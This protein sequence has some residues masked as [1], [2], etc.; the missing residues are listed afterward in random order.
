MTDDR[1]VL[2]RLRRDA[3]RQLDARPRAVE[4]ASVGVI[5]REEGV[6]LHDCARLASPHGVPHGLYNISFANEPA[7]VHEQRRAL[8]TRRAG[9]EVLVGGHACD[10]RA[11]P[12]HQLAELKHRA[13]GLRERSRADAKVER[14]TCER[15]RDEMCDVRVL[16]QADLHR[17]GREKR[18]RS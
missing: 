3:V 18:V 4:L 2:D 1:L 14:S 8:G 11:R 12:R 17:T 9:A 15:E 13:G 6:A 16:E 7:A 10:R 5:E